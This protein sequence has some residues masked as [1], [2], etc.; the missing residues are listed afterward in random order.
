MFIEDRLELTT[1][2]PFLVRDF[3][4]IVGDHILELGCKVL[5]HSQEY[6]VLLGISLVVNGHLFQ[7]TLLLASYVIEFFPQNGFE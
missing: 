2:E 7:F 1:Q 3:I 6:L 4:S 5:H